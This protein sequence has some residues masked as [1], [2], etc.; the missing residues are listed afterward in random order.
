MATIC[1]ARHDTRRHLTVDGRTTLCGREVE[2][3]EQGQKKYPCARC[4]LIQA[5]RRNT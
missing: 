3:V 2:A 1:L 4:L 5:E